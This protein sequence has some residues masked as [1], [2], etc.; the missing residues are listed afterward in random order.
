MDSIKD[1]NVI[2][3]KYYLGKKFGSGSFGEIYMASNGPGGETVALKLEDCK[4]KHAQL[5]PEAKICKA[6]QG[7]TG[8]PRLHWYGQEN[9]FNI[10]V[11]DLLGPS[12]ED[13]FN[14][15]NRK[16]SLKTV[17]MLTDQMISRVEFVHSRN[18]IHR[19][20]KPDNFLIGLKAKSHIVYLIDFG[21][22]KKYRDPKT[23]Q[24]IPY[25]ENKNLTGTARY[26]SINAHLGIEQSRRDDLEAI[27]YVIIY[28]T[29]GYLPWQG[30]KANNKQEKYHK[31]MEKKMTTPVEILC[32]GLPVEFSIYLNYCRTLRFEDKPDYGYL[33]KMFKELFLREGYESDFMY[34]WTL[35]QNNFTFDNERIAININTSG[36]PIKV[37]YDPK[38]Y[39]ESMI[40]SSRLDRTVDKG[41]N[42]ESRINAKDDDKTPAIDMA[43]SEIKGS[44]LNSNML[45]SNFQT[46]TRDVFSTNVAYQ[47]KETAKEGNVNSG[48][49]IG[50]GLG[51][52]I[53]LAIPDKRGQVKSGADGSGMDQSGNANEMKNLLM[54][55]KGQ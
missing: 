44:M 49:N 21:L 42:D 40:K 15:C 55:S 32:K 38:N 51:E 39:D 28:L 17:L 14:L 35:P 47:N 13:L 45:R 46:P 11:I 24:H 7:G 23:H 12:L 16:F 41:R 30:I 1:H 26:A 19:D 10:M 27:G 48:V 4:S 31:I 34:D 50:V 36:N 8:I 18:H 20:I 22:A 25:R 37:P 43:E 9:S 52:S 53:S 5:L 54:M 29:K 2:N 3:G 33:R 6:L